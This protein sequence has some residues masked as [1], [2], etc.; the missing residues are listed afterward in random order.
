MRTALERAGHAVVESATAR[1]ALNAL[2]IE[3]PGVVLLDFALPDRDGFELVPLVKKTSAV[4]I[5]ISARKAT[6]LKVAVLDLGADDYITKPFDTEKVL[7][8]IHAGLRHRRRCDADEPYVRAGDVEI[9]L[10]ARVILFRGKE[11]HLPPKE[12]AFLAKLAKHPGRVLTHSHLLQ[13]VWG[14]GHKDDVDY[15]RVTVCGLRSGRCN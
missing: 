5:V 9:D 11:L 14:A 2:R 6:D 4:A 12:Y 8:R 7:A 10:A 3:K 15:A 13:A 1:E